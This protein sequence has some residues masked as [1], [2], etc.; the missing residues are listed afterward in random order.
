MVKI[1]LPGYE[2]Q[3]RKLQTQA[4][5]VLED[6]ETVQSE[7]PLVEEARESSHSNQEL[8]N[9]LDDMTK[10]LQNVNWKGRIANPRRD[11]L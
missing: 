2:S 6:A 9:V 4:R 3:K 7:E 1:H 11:A 10:L 5:D 8:G